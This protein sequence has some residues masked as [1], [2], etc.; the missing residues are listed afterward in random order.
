MKPVTV[1]DKTGCQGVF[2]R[3]KSNTFYQD[4]K[5]QSSMIFKKLKKKSCKGCEQCG[6]L[7]EQLAENVGMDIPV[8]IDQEKEGGVYQLG[9][10][11][12]STDFETGIVD[13][14]DISFELVKQKEGV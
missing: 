2:F 4:G 5:Y 11:N 1:S 9:W 8:L 13:D 7:E 12:L 14:W 6:Y 3:Y 10:T